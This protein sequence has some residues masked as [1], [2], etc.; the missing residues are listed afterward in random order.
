MLQAR[1]TAYACFLLFCFLSSLRDVISELYFKAPESEVSPIYTLFVYSIVTQAIAALYVAIR[2]QPS[3]L[4]HIRMMAFSKE[5]IYINFF[6]LTAFLFYFLAI[7]SPLG[8]AMNA[9]VD[10]GVGPT[11]TALVGAVIAKERL[12]KVFAYSAVCSSVGIIIFAAPRLQ[13]A[14]LSILWLG[15]IFLALLSVVSTAIYRSYFKVLL[16]AGTDKA[17]IVLLR[18]SGLSIV[19]GAILIFQPFLF[20]AQRFIETAALGLIGFAFPLFLS[21]TILQNVTIRSFSMLLF[22]YPVLTY[23][24][25]ASV[26]LVKVYGS[27][28]V[29][30]RGDFHFDRAT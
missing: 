17:A 21:L 20:S 3:A 1:I 13:I 27:D 6:T 22:L 12:N 26:G 5:N 19:L 24:G 28:L 11:I 2:R 30:G 9:F 8:A 7:A 23:W 14:G 18:M 15:G 16:N 10:Y 25:S 29:S 4:A